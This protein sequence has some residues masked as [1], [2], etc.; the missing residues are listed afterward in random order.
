[1]P[2]FLIP[3]IILI[4]VLFLCAILIKIIIE[5]KKVETA[6]ENF[7]NSRT[8]QNTSLQEILINSDT[9]AWTIQDI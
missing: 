6:K 1:M 2:D 4:V 3:V 9:K 8:L 5:K 7:K